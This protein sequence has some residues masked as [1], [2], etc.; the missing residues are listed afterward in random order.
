MPSSH[1]TSSRIC[2]L[3]RAIIVH[4][5]RSPPSSQ[6]LSSIQSRNVARSAYRDPHNITA[7]DKLHR[8]QKRAD[9]Q[10][11]LDSVLRA[12]NS[13]PY[14]FPLDTP[15]SSSSPVPSPNTPPPSSS[16]AS[17]PT[18]T[19]S[20]TPSSPSSSPPT[21]PY[22]VS[23]TKNNQYPVY[24]D[25]KSGGN[26]HVTILRRLDGDLDQLKDHLVVGLGLLTKRREKM[27][28][29]VVEPVVV[30]RVSRQLVIRGWR[31]PEVRKWL[32]ERGF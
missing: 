16:S 24:H 21:L 4:P 1:L 5:S 3:L 29:R 2:S 9:K 31:A 18:P 10:E 15:S 13:K 6:L 26:R 20:S 7:L 30:N 27:K 23:R 17:T 11:I 8:R 12:Q 25:S 32:G 19:P 22:H 14:P 28:G